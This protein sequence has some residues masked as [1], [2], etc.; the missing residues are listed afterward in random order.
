[1]KRIMVSGQKSA[2]QKMGGGVAAICG[3]FLLRNIVVQYYIKHYWEGNKVMHIAA[4]K[5][6]KP[7]CIDLLK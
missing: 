7:K 5:N 6:C 4:N 3:I 1:M 2:H